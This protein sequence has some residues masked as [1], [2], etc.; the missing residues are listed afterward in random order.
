[1]SIQR[2]AT[3]VWVLLVCRSAAGQPLPVRAPGDAA[4]AVA[5]I[6]AAADQALKKGDVTAARRD[7]SRAL[8]QAP[9]TPEIYQRLLS[10][11][12]GEEDEDVRTLLS[13]RLVASLCD[14]RGAYKVDKD[15]R[16]LLPKDPVLKKVAAARALAAAE[17]VRYASGKA[18][19]QRSDPSD[20][21]LARHAQSIARLVV[22]ESPPLLA[23]IAEELNDATSPP[24]E[25]WRPVIMA[26]VRLLETSRASGQHDAALAAA[27]TLVGLAA[28]SEFPDLMGP[29]PP[30]LSRERDLAMGALTQLRA[31]LRE[32][33]AAPFT[34]AALRAMDGEQRLRFTA[35]HTDWAHPAVGVTDSG[36][37]RVET[38]CGHGTLLGALE[39]IEQ[40]HAR[41]A[42]WFGSDPFDRPGVVRI[43]P[44]AAG[45]EQEGSPHWWA[46][47]FQSG[48]VT[49]VRFTAGTVVSL[50]SLL[51]HELTHRFDGALHPGLPAWMLEG[52]AVFTQESYARTADTEFVEDYADYRRI[53][54]TWIKGYGQEPT[55]RKLLTGDLEDYRD[56]YEAGYALFLY[57]F[58]YREGGEA[59]Y[60]GALP[61]YFAASAKPTTDETT[62]FEQHFADGA[63]GRPLGIVKFAAKFEAFLKDFYW[64]SIGPASKPYRA[65]MRRELGQ[66]VYDFP[67]WRSTRVR[68]EP[69]FGDAQAAVAADVLLRYGDLDGALAAMLWATQVD[70]ASPEAA[71]RLAAQLDRA[72]KAE[73]AWVV[74]SS[75]GSLAAD[76][77]AADGS[78]DGP[79]PE[80]K[81][82]SKTRAY[83]EALSDAAETYRAAG[84]SL[85]AASF[86]AE[87]RRLAALLGATALSMEAL[88][89]DPGFPFEGPARYLFAAGLIEDEL[90]DHQ[91]RRVA[92][93]FYETGDGRIHIGRS[94]AR[95]GTG[96]LDRT[97]WQQ[98]SFVRGDEW[99]DSR[100]RVSGRVHL[101]TTDVEG[102]IVLGYTRRD[103]NIRLSFQAGAD[104]YPAGPTGEPQVGEIMVTL[105]GVRDAESTFAGQEADRRFRFDGAVSSFAF[106]L[107]VDDGLV[108]A[109]IDGKIVGTYHTPDDSPI[110]G[111]VG[112]GTTRGAYQ[113]ESPTVED[114][115]RRV[116]AGVRELF[117][118]GLHLEE[119]GAHTRS[120]MLNRRV[121]GIP[122]S[123]EV[124]LAL[125]VPRPRDKNRAALAK[126]TVASL[127]YLHEKITEAGFCPSW[128]VALPDIVTDE[129]RAAIGVGL[130]RAPAVSCDVVIHHKTEPLAS[131][132]DAA[133]MV[134]S[135]A[136]VIGPDGV[137]RAIAPFNADTKI[138]PHEFVHW[139]R[140]FT[141]GTV[142]AKHDDP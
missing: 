49:T 117:A 93:L 45:L 136:L 67:I 56:N 133:P 95:E 135:M 33:A 88:A 24:S 21:L 51:T 94:K 127:R 53:E 125:W 109:F 82:L 15:L 129:E 124:T 79:A 32:G 107:L 110:E 123:P 28:Q 64:L 7:L 97:A 27:R 23:S 16:K 130:G 57:L 11:Y 18:R 31:T 131:L 9:F 40:H 70:E 1:M 71:A 116:A 36:S 111:Y 89:K 106:E 63:D 37:Y 6:L 39:T 19:S 74:R 72:G 118:E 102:T 42:G 112:F 12:G 91:A 68:A 17:L 90:T 113:V 101:T 122:P 30:D 2:I 80:L 96:Q 134:V 126:E 104:R 76:G 60:R 73:A 120:M 14:T 78:S 140:L 22:A 138:I 44:D 141:R 13:H 65:S 10:T 128:V 55:L 137:L 20:W 4:Q 103:R 41:L 77:P 114:W 43:V 132:D 87:H 98:D 35:Q 100:Y 142:A 69:W 108:V 52:R 34:T 85:S 61:A 121:I 50:G 66:E 8:W 139:L 26:L 54:G 86:A 83:A 29:T 38:T 58:T 5:P 119:G 92:D 47:G 59:L 25:P 105:S 46:G 81:G 99:M 62:R 48:D 3:L 75:A 84:L 115:N